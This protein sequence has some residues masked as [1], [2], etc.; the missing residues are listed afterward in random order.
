M[1]GHRRGPAGTHD[2]THRP[3]GARASGQRGDVAVRGDTATRD[4]AHD[5]QHACLERAANTLRARRSASLRNP[6]GLAL[7]IARRWARTGV[8]PES[9]LTEEGRVSTSVFHALAKQ[10]LAPQSRALILP[11]LDR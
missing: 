9:D 2:G 3:P 4:P 8:V 1:T 6:E 5:G 11:E 10:V 7:L